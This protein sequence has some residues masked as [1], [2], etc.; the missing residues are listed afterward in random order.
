MTFEGRRRSFGAPSLAR[1]QLRGPKGDKGDRGVQG[2]PGADGVLSRGVWH[3]E[4]FGAT[5]RSI[6]DESAVPDA[7]R[8]ANVVAFRA[9]FAAALGNIV[10]LATDGGGVIYMGPGVYHTNDS[11]G[12]DLTVDLNVSVTLQGLGQI[13]GIFSNNYA[14]A[15]LKFSTTGGNI[16][17]LLV[18]DVMLRGGREGLQLYWCAYSHFNRIYFWGSKNFA[19]QDQFGGNNVFSQCRFDECAQG[20]NGIEADAVFSGGSHDNFTECE[21]GEYCGGIVI[22]TGNLAISNSRFDSCKLR[23]GKF[24]DYSTGTEKNVDGSSPASPTLYL[25]HPAA[26]TLSGGRC[27][28]NACTGT[29]IARFVMAFRGQELTL[30]GCRLQTDSGFVGFID[31]WPNGVLDPSIDLVLNINATTFMFEGLSGYL[32]SDAEDALHDSTVQCQVITVSPGAMTALSSSAPSLT[33]P[34]SEN[35][36]VNIRTFPR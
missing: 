1:P 30:S 33:N 7:E 23:R 19:L 11:V 34:G 21:F 6:T 13:S 16:R 29:S 14:A 12:Y 35:N 5:P 18:Q 26:I 28:I 27:L 20:V 36:L 32:I 17:D 8:T 15:A 2:R 4:D 25:T 3:V 9:A 10:S 24:F 22:T 31:V